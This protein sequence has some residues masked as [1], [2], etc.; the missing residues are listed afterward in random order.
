MSLSEGF[1]LAIRWLHALAALAWVGGSVFYL[2]VL[3]PALRRQTQ[4]ARE[5]SEATAREFRTLVDLCILV[6]LLTGTILAFDRLSQRYAD[7]DYVI[8]LGIKIT[9][10]LW[11][12][13]LAWTR[14]QPGRYLISQQSSAPTSPPQGWQR[15]SRM[16]S[17]AN[18]LAILGIVIFLL[19]DL[20]KVLFERAIAR[21]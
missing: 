1:L 12:F 9:L 2:V 20:L 11:M 17:G 7:M 3:R 4:S 8:V 15:V 14:R 16:L 13:T 19:A 10:A 6:L 21:G 18:L 5:L